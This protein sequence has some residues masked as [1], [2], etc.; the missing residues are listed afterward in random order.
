MPASKHEITLTVLGSIF[1][2]VM[3][4]LLLWPASQAFLVIFAALLLAIFINALASLVPHRLGLPRAVVR[5]GV[6]LLCLV[7]LVMFFFLAGPRF[8]AQ[9][10]ELSRQL[11]RAVEHLQTTVASQSWIGWLHQLPLEQLRPNALQLMTGAS[12]VFSTALEEVIDSF[13]VLFIGIYLSLQPEVYQQGFMHLIPKP[14]R[15]PTRQFLSAL[16]HALS[17]WLLGRFVS[18]TAVGILIVIAMEL[19]DM[20]LALALGIIA[21]LLYFVPYAGPIM[22]AIP[23]VLIGLLQSPLTALKVLIIYTLVLLVE[24]NFLTPMIQ[25]RAVSLPPAILLSAQLFMGIFY[26]IFGILLAAPLAVTVIVS[27][28]VFYVRRLLG[29]AVPLLGQHS[30]HT[31]D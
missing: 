7:L 8:G 1:L 19:I 14:H 27:V 11:P 20:P 24:G 18:M 17:W 4:L 5:S 16:N 2:A 28:Q 15:E 30:T 9:L 22:A 31:S 10:S 25:R 21:G 23:A 6:I 13:M 3:V 29:D 12:G 26:G